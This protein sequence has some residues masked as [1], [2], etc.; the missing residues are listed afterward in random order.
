MDGWFGSHCPV[1][2][3]IKS[4]N[5]A[6][7]PRGSKLLLDQVAE[8]AQR[9][10]DLVGPRYAAAHAE[11]VAVAVL[12]GEECAGRDVNVLGEGVLAEAQGVDLRREFDP[13]EVAALGPA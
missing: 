11:A 4:G 12:D 3:G 2:T 8:C 13:D 7:N 9:G 5:R 10:L 6:R 1:R